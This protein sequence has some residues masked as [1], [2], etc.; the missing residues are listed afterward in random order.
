MSELDLVLI[1]FIYKSLPEKYMLENKEFN[2]IWK[3]L[4]FLWISV[5]TDRF[6]TIKNGSFE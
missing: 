4:I 3:I 6:G 2:S 1:L 5:S